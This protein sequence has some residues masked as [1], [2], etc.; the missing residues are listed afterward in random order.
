ME[1]APRPRAEAVLPPWEASVVLFLAPSLTPLQPPSQRG[2]GSPKRW[3]SR[4][5]TRE[6]GSELERGKVPASLDLGKAAGEAKRHPRPTPAHP[7]LQ[8]LDHFFQFLATETAQ[9]GLGAESRVL[10]PGRHLLE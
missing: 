7:D 5:Q 6:G 8:G 1:D 2:A 3:G 4:G 9:C 10:D